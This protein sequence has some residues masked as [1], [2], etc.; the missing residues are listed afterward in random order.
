MMDDF[1]DNYEI[2]G[3]KMKPVLPGNTPAEKLE[4]YRRAFLEGGQIQVREAADDDDDGDILQPVDLDE[5]ADRW[6]CETIL[7]RCTE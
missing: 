4:S 2:L 6:D 3:R 5:R 1:L 7:S